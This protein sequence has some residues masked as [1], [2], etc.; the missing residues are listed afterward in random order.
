MVFIEK[1]YWFCYYLYRDFRWPK[2]KRPYGITCYIGLP[3]CGK[4]L[5]MVQELDRLREEFPYALIGTNFGYKFQDFALKDWEQLISVNNGA[6]GVIFGFDEVQYTFDRKEWDGIP[7]GILEIFGQNRKH[8]KQFLCTSQAYGDVSIDLRRRC[9]FIIE[10][11]NLWDRNRWFFL[12]YFR[13]EDYALRD[14]TRTIRIRAKRLSFIA[15][16]D[17]YARYN[18]FDLIPDIKIGSA[19]QPVRAAKQNR[20][21]GAA[22]VS[23]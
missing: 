6:D 15:T 23:E 16:D 14:T 22:K 18:T 19:L 20:S 8:A 3:G 1:V 21:T 5:S 11:Q 10:C 7:A 12:K 17:L 4:T 9:K 2:P 13:P